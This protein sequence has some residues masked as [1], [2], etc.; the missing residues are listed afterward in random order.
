MILCR[1]V[2][3]KPNARRIARIP[4]PEDHL[5]LVIGHFAFSISGEDARGQVGHGRAAELA[6]PS[7]VNPLLEEN[8]QLVA[9]FASSV[10]TLRGKPKKMSNARWQMPNDK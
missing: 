7:R 3:A 4:L 6:D 5:S 1:G 10:S 2:P 9:I 8:E